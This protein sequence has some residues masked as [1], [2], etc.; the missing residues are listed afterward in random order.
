[1]TNPGPSPEPSRKGL[2]VTLVQG[3]I[4]A[5]SLVGTTAIPIAVQRF[6]AP[7]TPVSSPTP[8]PTQVSSPSPSIQ[9]TLNGLSEPQ[10][11]SPDDEKDHHSKGK[12]KKK[13]K[14]DD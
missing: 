8:I 12:G 14:K 6:M 10:F 13:G 1:M 4:G 7:A 11:S 3:V 5:A 9:P 2:K